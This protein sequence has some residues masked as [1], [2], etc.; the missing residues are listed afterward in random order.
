MTISRFTSRAHTSALY[1]L[2]ARAFVGKLVIFER[3]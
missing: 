1:L 3:L 2:Y